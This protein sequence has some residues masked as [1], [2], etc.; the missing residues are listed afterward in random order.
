[1]IRLIVSVASRVW[2]V[3]RTRWPVSAADRAVLGS[4]SVTMWR[5]RVRFVVVDHRRQRRALA[6]PGGA[7][8]ED[9]PE[10]PLSIDRKALSIGPSAIRRTA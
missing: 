5:A 4:S 6:R 7:D 1:M 10:I 2:T 3:E 8:N 9:D